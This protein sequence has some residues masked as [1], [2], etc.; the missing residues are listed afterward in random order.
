MN[1]FVKK[2]Q[3]VFA[4]TIL[5]FLSLYMISAEKKG[6]DGAKLVGQALS[7]AITPIQRVLLY[8]KHTA[9]D[10]WDGYFYLVGLK[11][12]NSELQETVS[13]LVKENNKLREELLLNERL[14]ELVAFKDKSPFKIVAAPLLA[15]NTGSGWTRTITLKKG[16]SEG[17]R[18]NMP[19]L[20]PTGVVGR[21]ID[22]TG[23]TSNALLLTDPRS[24]IDVFIQNTR[25][26]GL[27]EGTGAGHL[28]LKYIRLVEEVSVGDRVVTTGLSGIYPSGLIVGTVT[29]A[30]KGK[31]NFFK[32]IHIEP[33]TNMKRLEEVLIVTETEGA[34]CVAANEGVKK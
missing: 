20:S 22:V 21:I 34:K 7:L 30:K 23:A 19:V 24:N 4:S 12:E 17:I 29:K 13:S 31:N 15:L 33:A 27:A 28:S 14:K 10:T 26:R 32:V 8:S 18:D 5:C 25:I 9:G 11:G 16:S 2:H 1:A 3:I 6:A